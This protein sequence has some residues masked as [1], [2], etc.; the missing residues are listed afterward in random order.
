ML[1]ALVKFGC[2][3]SLY[4]SSNRHIDMSTD[5]QIVKSLLCKFKFKFIKDLKIYKEKIS[6]ARS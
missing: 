3:S 2:F 5:R 6:T 4:F 1:Y